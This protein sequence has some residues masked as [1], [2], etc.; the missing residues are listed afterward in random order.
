MKTHTPVS[1]NWIC[2]LAALLLA[3]PMAHGQ[4]L[5]SSA[6]QTTPVALFERFINADCASCWS[7]PATPVAQPGMLTLDWIVPDRMGE[8]AALAAA[9]SRDALMR[10]EALLREQPRTQD[11]LKTKVLGQPGIALSVARGVVVGDYLGAS[12]DLAVPLNAQINLPLQTWLVMV[13][14]LPAGFEGSPISRN[15]VRNVL[16]LSWSLRDALS[17]KEQLIFSELRPMNIPHGA[18]AARLR[19]AG[20]VRDAN[21]R[22]LTAAVSVCPEADKD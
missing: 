20:W 16:Q 5:C 1:G 9:A 15:L 11:L 17:N 18:V 2:C 13:E 6:G 3:A 21:G 7:D 22:V 19:V 8:D 10:L 4:T 14:E 12:I